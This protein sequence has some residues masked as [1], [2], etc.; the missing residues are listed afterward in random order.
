[1]REP[2]D[3]GAAWKSYVER[4]RE[5]LGKAIAEVTRYAVTWQIIVPLVQVSRSAL[6]RGRLVSCITTGDACMFSLK[7]GSSFT[8]E[9]YPRWLGVY[10][11]LGKREIFYSRE[12]GFTAD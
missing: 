5:L 7:I 10:A 6:N 3:G 2:E 8:I 12:M 9:I 1:V 4:A 11:K